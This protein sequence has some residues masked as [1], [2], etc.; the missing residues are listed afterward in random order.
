LHISDID[1]DG[2]PDLLITAQT[3]SL[4]GS[5]HN[6]TAVFLNKPVTQSAAPS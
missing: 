2:Y 1:A 6:L 4:S 3:S 5:L